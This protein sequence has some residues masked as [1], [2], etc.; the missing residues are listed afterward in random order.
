M[1]QTLIVFAILFLIA[2]VVVF[3]IEAVRC[4][5]RFPKVSLAVSVILVS[6]SVIFYK[7]VEEHYRLSFIPPEFK[8]EKVLYAKEDLWGFG[9]S[10]KAA[11]IFVYELP[12]K[13]ASELREQGINY[14]NNLAR[15]AWSPGSWHGVYYKWEETPI[16]SNREWIYE[17]TPEQAAK[18]KSIS[19]SIW[20]YLDRYGFGLSIDPEIIRDANNGISASGSYFSY[21][22]KGIIIINP[23]TKKVIYAYNG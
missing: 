16:P 15:H 6:G 20:A 19:P 1:I 3:F 5:S 9:P 12:E 4:A 10:G 14:L 2:I 21:G 17:E 13:T 7:S 23:K 11:G 18:Q 22:H 8:V